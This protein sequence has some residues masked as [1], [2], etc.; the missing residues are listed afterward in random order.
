MT[1]FTIASIVQG[2]SEAFPV[3][4]SAHLI[5]L[6]H[7]MG[8]HTHDASFPALLHL[9]SLIALC[10]LFYKEVVWVFKGF[11]DTLRGQKTREHHFLGI[12]IVATIPSVITG[13]VMHFMKWEVD[14]TLVMALCSISFGLLLY[15]VDKYGPKKLNTPSILNVSYAEALFIGFFQTFALLP[16]VS[17]L[18]ICIT[19]GRLLGYSLYNSTRLAFV[20]GLASIGGAL[21]LKIPSLVSFEKFKE[22]GMLGV[23]HPVDTLYSAWPYI[24]PILM[25][26]VISLV[27]I[28]GFLF[29]TKRY[30]LWPIIVY[31]VT[32]GLALLY[33]SLCQFSF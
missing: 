23:M 5:L 6:S 19:A 16:G 20:L 4:S 25:T 13:A 9:G 32:V 15:I 12:F 14:S 8:F 22:M 7:V 17:R 29:W 1:Y 3:S 28:G 27:C 18:G 26:A 10:L 21:T 24:S 33:I 2:I 30:P 11:A 31:R